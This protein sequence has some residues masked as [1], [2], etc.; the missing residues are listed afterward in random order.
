MRYHIID[1]I[2]GIAF[3][4]MVVHHIHY[5]NPKYHNNMPHY[6]NICGNISR[7]IFIILV[8]ISM[9]IVNKHKKNKKTHKKFK[10]PKKYLVLL[11]ALIVTLT[12]YIF[13][14]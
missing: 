3:I 7:T 14:L 11:S 12:T 4:L 10:I 1:L 8:G 13:L 2:R 9:S 5:F 6:V